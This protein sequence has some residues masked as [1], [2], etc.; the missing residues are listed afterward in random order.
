M[1]HTNA[2]PPF[3]SQIA[4]SLFLCGKSLHLLR[5]CS[6]TSSSY[7]T[8]I[9]FPELKFTFS[10]ND[11][12]NFTAQL[13]AYVN[14]MSEARATNF[15]VREARHRTA[16]AA[17]KHVH[18]LRVRRAQELMAIEVES[19]K[20]TN[21]V[22]QETKRALLLVQQDDQLRHRAY[23]HGV[24]VATQ[25]REALR[26]AELADHARRVA[27][28]AEEMKA[29]YVV[30]SAV[31]DL[32]LA[33]AEFRNARLSSRPVLRDILHSDTLG[34]D[35]E[36]ASLREGAKEIETEVRGYGY[37]GYEGE[38]LLLQA[39]GEVNT[40]SPTGVKINSINTP[41][42]LPET[43]TSIESGEGG[44]DSVAS[45]TLAP[46]NARE[47]LERIKQKRLQQRKSDE[48]LN[49]EAEEPMPKL[50]EGGMT[51][52]RLLDVEAGPLE[53]RGRLDRT[54]DWKEGSAVE[55]EQLLR[56]LSE[57]PL[58]EPPCHVEAGSVGIDE[59]E[60]I[61]KQTLITRLLTLPLLRN[62][63]TQTP[64]TDT[65]A[66]VRKSPLVG[67]ARL[68]TI[69][70]VMYPGVESDTVKLA[71]LPL[72]AVSSTPDMVPIARAVGQLSTIQALVCYHC[73]LCLN[74]NP[75]VPSIF[76]PLYPLYILLYSQYI[77]TVVMLR[78]LYIYIYIYI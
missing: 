21:V 38:D 27:I 78:T 51:G 64:A 10:T 54:P 19:K 71:I 53:R 59:T 55:K 7:L 66:P 74:I 1:W 52:A 48:P 18:V 72:L 75:L 68:S 30:K 46:L 62:D 70:K 36:E 39:R 22:I 77:Y 15:A 40:E 69:Q 67:G 50:F 29:E 32:A 37:V 73:S 12:A 9:P 76:T 63:A 65:R 49:S 25:Q 20:T 13:T 41:L 56:A 16:T 14:A 60:E 33:R 11:L 4:A 61:R 45:G 44:V 17:E 31:A 24:A 34:Y 26:V 5:T 23:A 58:E 35:R 43:G 2:C 6:A 8:Q 47:R 3:L 28:V 57:I 42:T